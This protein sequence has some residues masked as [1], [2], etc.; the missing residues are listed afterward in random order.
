MGNQVKKRNKCVVLDSDVLTPPRLPDF[1]HTASH[2]AN[3]V[4]HKFACQLIR[5]TRALE[6][7]TSDIELTMKTTLPMPR[8][9]L[10]LIQHVR[11]LV[12]TSKMSGLRHACLS[13]I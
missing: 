8:I 13:A 12:R 10:I 11:F 3:A 2:R 5:T 6:C 4:E 7:G 1:S 9:G